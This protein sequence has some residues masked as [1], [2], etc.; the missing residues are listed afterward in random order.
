MRRTL[1][2][3]AAAATL[4]LA[5]ACS[6][7]QTATGGPTTAPT[8]P[9]TT[10][11]QTGGTQATTTTP[12]GA[13]TTTRQ[14]PATTTGPATTGTPAP[15]CAATAAWGTG[16]EQL[17]GSSTDALYLVRSGR[18]DCYDRVVFDIN[19]PAAVGYSV[20]YVD[21]VGAEGTG[22]PITVPGHAA[23]Q[24]VVR[25][26]ELGADQGGHQPGR[27]LAATGDYLVSP[28]QVAS[29]PALRGVRF[30]GSFE[31][32]CTFAVGVRDTLPFRVFTL[33][34][35]TNQVRRVVVDIAH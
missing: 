20:G 35:T 18:H 21:V 26:P 33:L 24:V 10:T 7:G 27:I 31:G 6:G 3:L 22:N 11:S 9:A 34:D 16:A 12:P 2:T 29:W 25:A 28:A 13:T 8:A 23:L 5:T 1:I 15:A 4:A 17:A 30:G 19:G 14:A 32:Q